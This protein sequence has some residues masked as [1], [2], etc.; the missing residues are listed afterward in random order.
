MSARSAPS[1]RSGPWGVSQR[2]VP[3]VLEEFVGNHTH[4]QRAVTGAGR[5]THL[6]GRECVFCLLTRGSWFV[7]L[8]P[9]SIYDLAF[10]PDGTQLIIAAGNRLLVGKPSC[11]LSFTAV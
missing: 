1:G 11:P 3:E 6:T 4:A 9:F 7:C 10:K 5:V 8:F 2:G